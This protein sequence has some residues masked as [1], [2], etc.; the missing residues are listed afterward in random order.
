MKGD[1]MGFV[2]LA[3]ENA[4]LSSHYALERLPIR[5]H[6]IYI[7]SAGAQRCRNLQPDKAGA[8]NHHTFCR[9]RL[10][11]DR[12]TVSERAQIMKLNVIRAFYRQPQRVGPSG[13]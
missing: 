6:Y 1:A 8:D 2:K 10:G 11:N 9:R 4:N 7:N 5:S 3:N 13:Q 12:L